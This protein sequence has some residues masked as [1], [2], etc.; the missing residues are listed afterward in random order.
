M[1]KDFRRLWKDVTNT[2]DEAKAVR[3]L[4]EILADKEGRAFISRLERKDAELCIEILDHVSYNLDFLPL[5]P[6]R[7][8]LQG[9]AEAN[10]KLAEK[11][12]FF[13]ALR[14]LAALYGRLPDSIII[15]ERIETS[16]D[17]LASGG[18]ADV[19]RGTYMGCLVA[20]K[21]MRVAVQDDFL[22]MRKVGISYIFFPT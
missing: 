1:A 17:V 8:P 20:V 14:R 18:F 5:R 3:I 15:T 13:V 7:L 4:A 11:Q 12:A 10:L 21:T 2:I 19:R 9:I 6:L 22:K 16:G